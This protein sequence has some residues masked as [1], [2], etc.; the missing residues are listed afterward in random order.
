MYLPKTNVDFNTRSFILSS[1]GVVPVNPLLQTDFL[2]I[3]KKFIF[4]CLTVQAS[5]LKLCIISNTTYKELGIYIACSESSFS[6]LINLKGKK[7]KE[8]EREREL[9]IVTAV[10]FKSRKQLR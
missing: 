10:L 1:L 7:K 8:K 5:L 2:V 9:C 3:T 6:I 4:F